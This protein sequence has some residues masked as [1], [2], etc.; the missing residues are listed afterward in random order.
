LGFFRFLYVVL[1]RVHLPAATGVFEKLTSPSKFTGSHKNR[2]SEDRKRRL[3]LRPP[4]TGPLTNAFA[5]LRAAASNVAPSST[6]FSGG[7]FGVPV[8]LPDLRLLECEH[9]G[10]ER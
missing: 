2:F 8:Q 3:Q 5:C 7:L 1:D 10:R 9:V 6:L 4:H